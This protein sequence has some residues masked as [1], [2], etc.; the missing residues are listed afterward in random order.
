M[1]QIQ[2][3]DQVFQAAQRRAAD[4]GYSSVNE[5]IADVVVHDISDKADNYDHLFTP[6]R[7]AELD[8]ISTAI[9]SG[10]KT[11]TID[12][13]REHFDSKRKEWLA[14]HVS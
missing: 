10:G 8:R 1:P 4:G 11:Y 5:Y 7:L 14:N 3:D 2:L 12:E 13:V 9:K 6:E